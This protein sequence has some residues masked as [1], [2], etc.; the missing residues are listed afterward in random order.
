MTDIEFG[1]TINRT[2][3][4]PRPAVGANMSTPGIVVTAPDADATVFPLGKAIRFNSSDKELAGKLGN[5][6]SIKGQIDLLNNN[7]EGKSTEIVVVR[8]AEGASLADT[9]T[10]LIDGYEV[11]V[12]CAA[13]LGIT[14]RLIAIPG[15]THQQT[16][17]NIANPVVAVLHAGLAKLKGHAVVSG[18]DTTIQ[19]FTDWSETLAS[20][21]I[22]PQQTWVKVG[23]DAEKIDG[24]LGVIGMIIAR[25]SAAQGRPFHVPANRQMQGIV[26]VGRAVAY[27]MD[28]GNTE[29]QNLLKLNGGIIV[30]GESGVS[31]ALSSSGFTLISYATASSDVLWR[32]YNQTRGRD[33]IE[34]MMQSTCSYF[35]GKRNINQRTIDLIIQTMNGILRDLKANGDII[36]YAPVVFEPNKNSP[37]NLR[38]GKLRTSFRAEEAPVLINL[39]IES[40]RYRDAYATLA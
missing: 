14:P 24:A 38:L 17:P 6:G 9:Q 23:A 12:G 18:P 30:K 40:G 5:T 39:G 34:M 7:L 32:F 13:E 2:N 10:A 4:E 16:A 26:D 35:L 3:D 37:E 19:A 27:A 33:Y 21:R 28:D 20:D 15:Y 22:I 8:V 25:D 29:G 36:D 31:S 11:L 1:A